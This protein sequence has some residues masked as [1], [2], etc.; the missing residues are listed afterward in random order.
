MNT[1]RLSNGS[2]DKERIK[3]NKR[4]LIQYNKN[5]F[6]SECKKLYKKFALWGLIF[7]IISSFTRIIVVMAVVILML[8]FFMVKTRSMKKKL[9]ECNDTNSFFDE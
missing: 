8:A 3:K 2:I 6:N 5:V 7:I 4:S 9:K 1:Q